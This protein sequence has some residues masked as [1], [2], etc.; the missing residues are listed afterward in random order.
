M[1]EKDE[2]EKWLDYNERLCKEYNEAEDTSVLEKIALTERV[3]FATGEI[4]SATLG[5]EL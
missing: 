4:P 3:L 5:I 2:R 1:M